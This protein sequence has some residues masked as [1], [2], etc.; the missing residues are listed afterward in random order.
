MNQEEF[1]KMCGEAAA[2]EVASGDIVGLGTG[3]TVYYTIKYLGELTREEG[4]G[5]IGIPTSKATEKIAR[6][7]GIQ[8]GTLEEY[9]EL[10]IAIDGAD[11]VDPGLNL[12]KGGGGAHV[13]EK[14]VAS[15]AKRFIVV[16]DETKVV[17]ELNMAV[18]VEILPFALGLAMKKLSEIGATPFLRLAGSN[19]F[20][21]DNKNYVIDADFG[22]LS[23]PQKMEH[24]INKI[25]GVVDN[26]IFSDMTSEVLVGTS[27]GVKTL[28]L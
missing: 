26:G 16:A 5:I 15:A 18:P 19:Y 8:L 23:D 24:E 28:K 7:S 4:L 21:T 2:R 17:K 25:P 13:R 20:I 14:I 11:Q 3:S 22:A 10:D 27:Y 12:I 9:Q 1:K 6:E